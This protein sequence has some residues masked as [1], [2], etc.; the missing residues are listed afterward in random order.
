MKFM[1]IT[2]IVIIAV[3]ASLSWAVSLNQTDDFEGGTAEGWVSGAT[4][5]QVADGGPDGPGDGYLDISRTNFH[6]ATYNTLQWAGDYAAAGI[7]AIRLD[8][9]PIS[10]NVTAQNPDGIL[11]LRLVLFGPGGAFTST[12]ASILDP[13]WNTYEFDLNDMIFLT[14]SSAGPSGWPG[15]GT[16]VLADTL[17]AVSKL[18]IRNDFGASPT[19]IGSHP[20]HVTATLGMDNI[21]AIPLPGDVTGDVYVG[22]LDLTTII[23]NWGMTGATRQQ[24]DLS[25]DGTVSGLDYTEVITYWGTGTP[26]PEPGAIPEP[27]TLGLLVIGGLALLRRRK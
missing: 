2:S 25:G 13:G 5:T 10:V 4:V 27:T 18:L 6:I 12:D 9:N 17:D 22:G 3:A 11:G 16:E 23:T 1:A 8:A 14:G 19:P 24:G 7:S 26:P 20:P 15:G 21:T